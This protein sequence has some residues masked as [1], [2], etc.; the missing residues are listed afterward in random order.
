MTV[1][2]QHQH[3]SPAAA[4]AAPAKAP[5]AQAAPGAAP[6]SEV[7]DQMLNEASILPAEELPLITW[8]TGAAETGANLTSIGFA[9]TLVG[10]EFKGF[11]L[12]EETVDSTFDSPDGGK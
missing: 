6:G 10:F 11:I 3:R 1:K 4:A 2:E 12:G 5:A 9:K 7:L 8:E